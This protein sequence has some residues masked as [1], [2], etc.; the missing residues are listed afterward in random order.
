MRTRK[1]VCANTESC[2]LARG[3]EIFQVQKGS[4]FQC[5]LCGNDLEEV[6]SRTTGSVTAAVLVVA[7][8]DVLLLLAGVAMSPKSLDLRKN[9]ESRISQN[10]ILR[11]AGSN[12]IG[13]GLGPALAKAFLQSKGATNIEIIQ[14]EKPDEEVVQG[15]FPGDL[16]PSA[17]SI[18]A[19]GSAT[20][21]QSLAENRCDVGMASRRI[22]HGEAA[23]LVSMGDMQ[24]PASEHIVGL[25]GIAVIVNASNPVRELTRNEIMRIFTGATTNWSRGGAHGAINIYA[26][27]DNS[28]T[29]DTFKTLALAGK[30]LAANAQRFE[31]SNAVSDAVANDP[32]GIGF[33]AMP[34]IHGARAVAISEKETQALLPTRLTVS[35]EDYALSRRLYLYTP[36]VPGNRY[37]RQFV[38]YALSKQ[39]QDVVAANGF[40]AQIVR[41]EK[42][43]VAG[44]APDEYKQLTEGA[45]RLSLNFRFQNGDLEPDN[46]AELDLDRVVT[47]IADLNISGDKVMLLGFSD[48]LGDEENN[49]ELSL[50][51]AKTVETEFARRGLKPAVVKGFGAVLPVAS[52]DTE[53][54]RL[55]N[56]RVEVWVKK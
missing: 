33:I 30:P 44:G 56:R 29:Y 26:R 34:F 2:P 48:G 21:F 10:T 3:K 7:A 4:E 8:A 55:K 1:G 24:S 39:G 37:T 43:T 22:T 47:L 12:T 46:K 14:G 53:E 41:K 9:K 25:D 38:E 27:T 36:A 52:N 50:S 54:G 5:P 11:L 42:Q 40:I 51:R 17:I 13:E 35:T 15:I 28:G 23:N 20:A 45:E 16:T 6:S 31:D 19:H 18:S 49:T 32:N